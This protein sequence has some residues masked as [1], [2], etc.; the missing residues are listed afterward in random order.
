MTAG[1]LGRALNEDPI[2]N[3]WLVRDG[4]VLASLEIPRTRRG[5]ARGLIGRT[6][7]EGAMLLRP[8]RSVHSFGM[9]FDLDIAFV[10]GD[11]VVV[12]T[13]RLHRHRITPPVW[14][15]RAVVEAEAGTFGQ[16]DLS[17]GDEIEIREA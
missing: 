12:R 3:G 4:R 8:A 13:L 1:F 7:I 9:R 6:G 14:R 15:A 16:W 11:G 17:I 2:D 10:D 5:K